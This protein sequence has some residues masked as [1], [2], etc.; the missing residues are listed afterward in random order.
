MERRPYIGAVLFL[1]AIFTGAALL[2]GGAASQGPELSGMR[3]PERKALITRSG[4]GRPAPRQRG[5]AVEARREPLLDR[6]Q[7]AISAAD[8]AANGLLDQA[9]WFIQLYGGVQ[10]LSD[11]TVVEDPDPRYSVVKLSDGTLTFVNSEPLDVSDHGK[12]V[13]RLA[14]VLDQRDIPLLYVQAPQ[15]LE[16][17]DPRLPQGVTDYGNDYAD[18]LLDML[19]EHGVDH[20]DLRETLA[21]AGGEWR[22]WFFRTDH[23]WTPEAAFTA[24]QTLSDVLRRDYGFHIASHHTDPRFF[25]QVTYED[26]FLG[27]QGKR[28]GTLYGGVDDITL[29]KP[30]YSTDFTYSVPIY[31]IE[32]TGAFDKSLLFPERVEERDYF[33]GNPYTLYAGGDYPLAR[34]YNHMEPDGKRVMLLRDSYACAITPFLALDCGELITVDLRYF[35]D[36]L[37]TYVDWL[38]PDMV[39]VM[40]TAGSVGLDPLFDFFHKPGADPFYLDQTRTLP[41]LV[42]LQRP[43]QAPRSGHEKG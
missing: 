38:K 18:Q 14:G 43:G 11:R 20:L 6:A 2:L 4:D 32:R 1:G 33:G 26:F 3:L 27:S 10:A 22:D 41:P 34:I 17:D 29:W 16:Q 13:A 7:A 8:P 19:E 42:E 28:V 35:S 37:L 30:T 36:D 25:R 9:H 12:A 5:A 39:V 21:Q 31:E 15:K 24:H 23:H 40:Y